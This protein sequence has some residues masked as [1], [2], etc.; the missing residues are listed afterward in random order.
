MSS[1][2]P[3]LRDNAQAALA[4]V[5]KADPANGRSLEAYLAA[6][7]KKDVVALGEDE[8]FALRDQTGDIKCFKQKLVL[9]AANGGLVQPVYKGPFT[10]SA[11]GYEMWAE[12]AGACVMFPRSVLVQG[13]E[14]RN[15]YIER[16]P[17]NRRILNVYARAVAF[18]FSSKGL[19]M[20]CDWTT[21]FDVPSYRLI[22]LVGK[23]K[24]SPQAFRLLPASYPAPSEEEIDCTVYEGQGERQT[25]KTVKVQATWACYPFDEFTN[26]WVCTGHP[27][28]HQCRRRRS[29][30]GLFPV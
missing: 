9:S 14:E 12:A 22:D 23:A 10:I 17:T 18:R 26:L 13:R 8:A 5:M 3:D 11:Q 21:T 7:H 29:G 6:L 2:V 4:A 24:K 16:D 20:V 27:L 19:P 1:N 28:L 25:K 30:L 15:P